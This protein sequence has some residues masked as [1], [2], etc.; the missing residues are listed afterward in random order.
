MI[1]QKDLYIHK[2]IVP[3]IQNGL[4]IGTSINQYEITKYVEVKNLQETEGYIVT[5]SQRI[6]IPN[7]NIYSPKPE[8]VNGF[9]NYPALLT[10][11]IS[12]TPGTGTSVTTQYLIKYNPKTLNTTIM[13]DTSASD[14]SGTSFSQQHTTGSSTS[15][16]NSYG[17]S[18]NIGFF[19]D[20]LVGGVSMSSEHSDTTS[21][22]NSEGIDKGTNHGKSLT[23]SDSMSMKDW[24]SYAMIDINNQTPTWVWGQEYPWNIIQ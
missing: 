15:Q 8:P 17:S 3:I 14:S 18:A 9:E 16:T 5:C 2:E 22:S 1:N 13:S 7:Q 10:N 4:Q 12:I 24:G 19:G 11:A 23:N 6:I 21:Q 20:A